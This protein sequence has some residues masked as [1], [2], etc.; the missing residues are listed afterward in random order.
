M[1][2]KFSAE[3]TSADDAAEKPIRERQLAAYHRSLAYVKANRV[4]EVGCGEG[5]GASL[6]AGKAASVVAVD[7]SE[8]AL[9]VAR[10]RYGADN[11]EFRLMKVPP[12]DFADASFE[13]A[14]CFQM[15]EHLDEPGRLVAEIG[16][17][18]RN[19]GTALFATANKAETI[20]D[21]PYHLHEFSAEEFEELLE[22]HFGSTEMY[23][24]FGDESFMRYWQNNRKWV[25][26]F[27]RAD[28]FHLSRHLPRP[29]KQRLFDTVSRL[30]RA[31]LMQADPDLCHNIMHENFIF[32][33]NE[34]TGCL[35]FFAVCRKEPAPSK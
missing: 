30:M 27:M 22:A 28:I 19:D 34:F 21:N 11:I 2:R 9:R 7:H 33:R 16:R 35:D 24:V 6:L 26:T 5:I 10:A 17:V 4:L 13:T 32:R 3:R 18:L 1:S 31:R 12:I 14:V 20:S 23:G 25:S 15:V 29:L 8:K